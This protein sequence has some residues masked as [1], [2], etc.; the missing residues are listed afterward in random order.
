[1]LAQLLLIPHER[2]A[3]TAADDGPV[4]ARALALLAGLG[5]RV[6]DAL[7]LVQLGPVVGD[8]V[9]HP[10]EHLNALE[11][12]LGGDGIQ[13]MLKAAVF[14]PEFKLRAMPN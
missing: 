6:V 4:G 11:E 14:L 10:L 9:E 12:A 8:H 13:G 7:G 3:L 1:M 5:I 2:G